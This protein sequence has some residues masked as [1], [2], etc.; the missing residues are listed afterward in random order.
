[1]ES[2]RE[3]V[4]GCL[5]NLFFCKSKT[6]I[7]GW[8]CC[9]LLLLLQR[10]DDGLV[11]KAKEVGK[12]YFENG[13]SR[14]RRIANEV[15]LLSMELD[16]RVLMKM[17]GK[18]SK[19][20][21]T[22]GSFNLDS[23]GSNDSKGK[24]QDSDSPA[25]GQMNKRKSQNKSELT[26]TQN[27]VTPQSTKGRMKKKKSNF[28]GDE[29]ILVQNHL[30][31]S[32]TASKGRMMKKKKTITSDPKFIVQD[33][34]TLQSTSSSKG[35]SS[36]KSNHS[37]TI[38]QDNVN[39]STP[40]SKGMMKKKKSTIQI[41]PITPEVGPSITEPE[42]IVPNDAAPTT[43]S[44]PSSKPIEETF[45][46]QAVTKAPTGHPTGIV[47]NDASTPTSTAPST[48]EGR[49][50]KKKRSKIIP[51][52]ND[53]LD[54]QSSTRMPSQQPASIVQDDATSPAA[55]PSKGLMNKRKKSKNKLYGNGQSF[56]KAP[57]TQPDVIVQNDA[58]ATL[59]PVEAN[60]LPTQRPH[61]A[62]AG[63]PTNTLEPTNKA[64]LELNSNPNLASDPSSLTPTSVP[65]S[66][67]TLSPLLPSQNPTSKPSS[68]PSTLPSRSPSFKPSELPSFLPSWRPT[69]SPSARPSLLP[70]GYP[71]AVP[72]H[73]PS[74]YSTVIPSTVLTELPSSHPS[75]APTPEFEQHGGTE[76]PLSTNG[77]AGSTLSPNCNTP[78]DSTVSEM[79]PSTVPTELPSAYPSGSPTSLPSE[80]PTVPITSLPSASNVQLETSSPSSTEF[81][82]NSRT[83]VPSS[84][85]GMVVSTFS[86]NCNTPA[87][88][89]VSKSPAGYNENRITEEP[90]VTGGTTSPT[91]PHNPRTPTDSPVL[92]TQTPALS[93]AV[94]PTSIPSDSV[95][96]DN[97]PLP[98]DGGFDP[99]SGTETP[100]AA[101]GS[102]TSTKSPANPTIPKVTPI[103]TQKNTSE[104]DSGLTNVPSIDGINDPSSR[105][106]SAYPSGK[107][108]KSS[109]GT[110]S[111]EPSP[112]SQP[113][114]ALSRGPSPAPSSKPTS[115]PTQG[116][117]SSPSQ[118]PTNDITTDTPSNPPSI[119]PSAAPTL[120]PTTEPSLDP[121][122]LPT[123][124]P[125]IASGT[126]TPL[127]SKPHC[128]TPT[129]QPTRMDDSGFSHDT[130]LPTLDTF[131]T[132]NIETSTPL[133]SLPTFTPTEA[134]SVNPSH[135]PF[136]AH[137]D[138]PSVS[139][140]DFTSVPSHPPSS[141][142]SD[143][144]STS[145][146]DLSS[147]DFPTMSRGVSP[148]HLSTN[149]PS[150]TSHSTSPV[151]E[152]P[153]SDVLWVQHG[154]RIEGDHSHAAAGSSVA[155]N[156]AGDIM[157]IG[158]P[159]HL[160]NDVNQTG[161]VRV[162]KFDAATQAWYPFGSD[163]I[164]AGGFGAS[165]ALSSDGRTLA[166]GSPRAK[167]RAGL[168]AT[169]RFMDN[170]WAT[171][172]P[173]VISGTHSEDSC[174]FSVDISSE[175]S[176]I[177]I[178]CPGLLL[179]KHGYVMVYEYTRGNWTQ[180]G[181]TIIGGVVGSLTGYSVSLSGSGDKL[182]VG[183]PGVD[184]SKGS[185]SGQVMVYSY[186][187][188]V[189]G[190]VTTG[191]CLQGLAKNDLCGYSVSLSEDGKNLVYGCPGSSI[192][193]FPFAGRTV[194]ANLDTS[195][196]L[197]IEHPTQI[198]GEGVSYQMG[199][200]VAISGNGKRLVSTGA[201][202][203]KDQ[204]NFPG[205]FVYNHNEEVDGWQPYGS[206]IQTGVFHDKLAT[207]TNYEGN[208]VG[209][210]VV[211][212]VLEG[213]V[214][215]YEAVVME[216]EHYYTNSEHHN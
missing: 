136:P 145:P 7:G 93:P 194:I 6:V 64:T 202:P 170:K 198:Q 102:G 55:T 62:D 54:Q 113:T 146:S 25:K 104:G 172:G 125:I 105:Q 3:P 151:H 8:T 51:Q 197:W 124:A 201:V 216:E 203:T 137:S 73:T 57:T 138:S 22:T 129:E 139:P 152:H 19:G 1:M 65:T 190:W 181:S 163:I 175:G 72:S 148:S 189:S 96:V 9:V 156:H 120:S 98:T 42:I 2:S 95:G 187:S 174:G 207:A 69:P 20:S 130:S 107:P 101:D 214:V 215:A 173:S 53:E 4:F 30:Y 81:N 75:K 186:S 116:P 67:P 212:S 13:I 79:I 117:S 128:P 119:E 38:V 31:Q 92:G 100:T 140:S 85:Y 18:V 24:S 60:A 106:P 87:D 41:N 83:E 153:L 191:G 177:A 49:T 78:A 110:P 168:A 27:N 89:T 126:H 29:S 10:W 179:D 142:P 61:C 176:T 21:T 28:S 36:S 45:D 183:S 159:G 188:A 154:P 164:G 82:Q 205:A 144:P 39:Q 157:A 143:S 160:Q 35:R 178:G 88:S 182:A 208:I 15:D 196:H 122:A 209:V 97:T 167:Y 155:Y 206:L 91:V 47:Q 213:Y 99:N 193:L 211:G 63:T 26:L 166:V 44:L 37:G 52:G 195:N 147:S 48:S 14:T 192:G 114:F 58:P 180:R 76:V 127:T 71:S 59:T 43:T 94:S 199:R 68:M 17:T 161:L 74:D 66:L 5:M 131:D 123:A 204:D 184:S 103:P 108:S 34:V 111:G 165:V 200:S 134:P 40:R 210:G 158:I 11:V 150:K 23:D 169:F 16:Q 12:H 90:T 149:S 118:L 70:S 109:I 135:A 121:S 115:L 56:T 141:L 86:P 185:D 162:Y 33:N 50:M 32:T 77:T 46:E 80:H 84:T 133:N 112:S 132:T 171:L